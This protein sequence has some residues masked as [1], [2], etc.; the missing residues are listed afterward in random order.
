MSE[1]QEEMKTTL[2]SR[3]DY[4]IDSHALFVVYGAKKSC[5]HKWQFHP[6]FIS[7]GSQSSIY[8]SSNIL[9]SKQYL[10]V[11]LSL[12]LKEK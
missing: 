10:A 2:S 9:Q 4:Q 12:K 6:G 11:L 1:I 8:I 5:F 3:I 7:T